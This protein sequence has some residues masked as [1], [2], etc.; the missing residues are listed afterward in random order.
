VHSVFC[1]HTVSVGTAFAHLQKNKNPAMMAHR[2][3]SLRGTKQSG[4]IYVPD[5]LSTVPQ[6]KKNKNPA[7]TARRVPSLR[8]TKQSRLIYMPDG[9]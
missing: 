6:K 8:G 2:V 9:S 3:P 5:G 7:M 1:Q 4:L